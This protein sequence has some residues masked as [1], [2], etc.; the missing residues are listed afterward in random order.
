MIIQSI[1][2]A[3]A[4]I[5]LFAAV[6]ANGGL[7]EKIKNDYMKLMAKDYTADDVSE[8]FESVKGYSA[9]LFSKNSEPG[10]ATFAENT[11][12]AKHE[13]MSEEPL[14]QFVGGGEDLEFSALD[15]LEGICFDEYDISFDVAI[16]LENYSITSGFGYRI[17]PITGEPG[18]HTG[19]DMAA[20]YG[21]SI[22]AAADGT[23]ADAAYDDSYGYYVKLRHKDNTVTIYAHCSALCVS[24]GEKVKQGEKIAEVGST[25]SSTGN[26]LHFEMRKDNIRINPMYALF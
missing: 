10:Q 9:A 4:V 14:S 2:C 12:A 5:L 15:T 3:V 16:P 23:V 25:G 17:G 20:P 6:K 22:H 18:I 1:V 19:I 8:A 21:T 13:Q 26:H 11:S 7:G 24:A